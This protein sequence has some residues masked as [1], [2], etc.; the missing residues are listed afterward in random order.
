MIGGGNPAGR[1]RQDQHWLSIRSRMEVVMLIRRTI[2]APAI[3]A[4]GT[5]SAL[6]AALA[7]AFATPAVA[8]TAHYATYQA[9]GGTVAPN[10]TTYHS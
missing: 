3:L 9:S 10:M 8:A 6:V 7:A 4:I 5:A 1:G 2:L